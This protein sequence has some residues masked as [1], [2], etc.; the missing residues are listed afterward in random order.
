MSNHPLA[1]VF[2]FPTGNLM[3]KPNA[4]APISCPTITGAFLHCD[5]AR[6]PLGVCTILDGTS[7][8]S[9]AQSASDRTG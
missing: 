9:P 6:D 3:A 2:G 5:K 1:E 8:A 7:T 4:I